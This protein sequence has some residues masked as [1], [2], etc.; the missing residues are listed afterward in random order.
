MAREDK[1]K[2]DIKFIIII[3]FAVIC[4][5]A[6]YIIAIVR[7]G[8]SEMALDLKSQI[9]PD[10]TI[11][12]VMIFI[13]LFLWLGGFLYHRSS[14]SKMTTLLDKNVALFGNTHQLIPSTD[15]PKNYKL[16]E[17]YILYMNF[18]NVSGNQHWFSAF[19]ANKTILRRTDDNFMVKYNPKTNKL[20]VN[21]RIQKV[22]VQSAQVD[23]TGKIDRNVEQNLGLHQ[24]YEYIYVPNIPHQQWLQIAIII[25]NRFID[26]YLNK[27]I[28]KSTVLQNVP[29]PSNDSIMLG[30]DYHNPNAYIG[31][32]EYSSTIITSL[33]LKS[34]YFKNMNKLNIT[35]KERRQV[36]LD[37]TKLLYPTDKKLVYSGLTVLKTSLSTDDKESATES[38]NTIQAIEKVSTKLKVGD[39]ITFEIEKDKYTRNY[40]VKSLEDETITV[41]EAEIK[42]DEEIDPNLKNIKIYKYIV[43]ETE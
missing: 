3:I 34:L 25:N 6:P 18:D 35:R 1:E 10:R 30:Q 31:K 20:V 5:L 43:S 27:K 14:S 4:V 21:I 28:A 24:N 32:L 17:T 42:K 11:F 40:T 36:E 26:I 12:M 19:G 9:T 8:K 33:D 23:E 15:I 39:T 38:A 41:K 13:S 16:Q 7:K 2:R 22:D 37:V 29:I